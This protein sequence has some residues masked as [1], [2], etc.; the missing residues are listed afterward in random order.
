MNTE[1]NKLQDFLRLAV[2]RL[3]V[4]ASFPGEILVKPFC[5]EGTCT[6]S[7]QCVYGAIL[8]VSYTGQTWNLVRA[9]GV[10]RVSV[11]GR[12]PAEAGGKL[13]KLLNGEEL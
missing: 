10:N 3:Q 5:W 12:T 4:K 6:V 8:I 11:T 7:F 13:K 2:F 1:I 9:A